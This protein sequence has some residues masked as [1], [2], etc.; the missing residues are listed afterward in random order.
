MYTEYM[1]VTKI[2]YKF[3]A[4]C[5]VLLSTYSVVF[6]I[7]DVHDWCEKHGIYQCTHKSY[8]V[9]WFVIINI[10]KHSHCNK[11]QWKVFISMW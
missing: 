10:R 7:H 1:D 5:F 9:L 4:Q 2:I 11:I 6:L 3:I 8:P